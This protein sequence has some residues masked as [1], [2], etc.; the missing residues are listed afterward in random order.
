LY[1]HVTADTQEAL[2]KAVVKI[3]Q[4]MTQQP[5]FLIAKIP[6]GI[7]NPDSGYNIP[8]NIIGQK[9][10]NVKY[11]TQHSGGTRVQLKGR[12]SGYREPNETQEGD[13]P[14]YLHLSSSGHVNLEKAKNLA[15]GLL[16]KVKQNYAKFLEAKK[17]KE[18]QQ[19]QSSYSA[20]PYQQ[21]YAYMYSQQQQQPPPPPGTASTASTAAVPPPPPGTSAP[22]TTSSVPPPPGTAPTEASTASTLTAEQYQQYMNYYYPNGYPSTDQIT[23]P[24]KRKFEGGDPMEETPVKKTKT[25]DTQATS[26]EA[27][28]SNPYGMT[29]EEY[30]K[31]CQ[32]YYAQYYQQTGQH[33]GQDGSY[34]QQQQ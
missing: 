31:Y 7:E 9:G 24:N 23:S 8:A 1:L 22:S 26:S 13:E 25:E 34:Q 14:M 3:K 20:D 17:A 30:Y 4:I 21:Y 10:A 2:D 6:V 32:E 15:E 29:E 18:E 12:G 16:R 28:A 27:A 19:Q 33:Y 11:I 5:S